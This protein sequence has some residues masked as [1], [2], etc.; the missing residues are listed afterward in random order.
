MENDVLRVNEPGASH[1]RFQPGKA[2]VDQPPEMMGVD[3]VEISLVNER[4][5]GFDRGK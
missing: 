4:P 2:G 3:E 1:R 5:Q